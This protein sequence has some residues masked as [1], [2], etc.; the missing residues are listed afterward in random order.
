MSEN[1]NVTEMHGCIVCA[2]VYNMLVVYNP[3][4]RLVDC[5]VTS[6]GGRRV[7]D[8]HKALVACANHT[9][10]EVDAAY[11]KWLSRND[12]DTQQDE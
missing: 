1:K 10:A 2:K 8:E 6:P 11:K 4:G 7:M 3:Q 5:T 12:E 9:S